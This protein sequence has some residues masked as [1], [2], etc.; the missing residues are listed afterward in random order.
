MPS[1]RRVLLVQLPIPSLGPQPIR[2]NVPLAAGY[3]KLWAR[4]Q[5]LDE[6]LD[7][8]ILPAREVNRCG[9][10]ALVD[11]IDATD[12]ALVGFTCYVW[13]IDRTLWAA[14]ELKRRRP[15]TLIV[16]G[17]PE[18]TAD[19][20]W[21][22]EHGA[23]DIAVV[24]EGEQTF[25]EVL[26]TCFEHPR[27]LDPVRG[28]VF[29]DG[30]R[31]VRTPPRHPLASLDAISSP[32]LAGIL[33]AADQEQL[34]LETVRGCV[35]RCKFCYYPKAYDGLYFVSRERVLLN[36]AHARDRGAREVYILDPTLNQRRDFADFLDVLREG[37]P[38]GRL[39]YH[40]ELRGEGIRPEHARRMREANFKEV[41]IGLQSVDPVAQKT[42]DRP[43]SLKA[44]ERGVRALQE[45]GIRVKADL[46][47]GL[48]GDRAESVR[49]GMHFLA[50]NRLYDDI[51]L[52]Q[53]SVLP[54]TEF[55]QTA[56]ELGIEFQPRPPYYALRTPDLSLDEIR[57]LQLE[58]EDVFGVEFDP[59]GPPV[60]DVEG[61]TEAPDGP[62]R[63]L[64]L[65]LDGAPNPALPRSTSLAFTLWLR[66]RNPYSQL[67]RAAGAV[68]ALLRPNPFTTL[69][70]VI[71]TGGEF[72][73][74]V[75]TGLR[76]A[77]AR[78]ENSY[79][80][81]FFEFTPS[82][83][84]GSLRFVCVF[85]AAKRASIDPD[86]VAGALRHS[87]VVWV[88]PPAGRDQVRPAGQAGEWVWERDSLASI[89]AASAAL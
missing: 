4:G 18:V 74:D 7:V 78:S 17:G 55:R 61:L 35:F 89:K 28:L 42:M 43:T 64:V 9:D 77:S 58:A 27:R 16:L 73:L 26:H 86:W 3:L 69:Q 12:P 10:Q 82:S 52:F 60:L 2:G 46:I 11:A 37:N 39:E 56:R 76:A 44:F 57:A 68:R 40:A 70:L 45:E 13:N 65:D 8:E 88:Q 71:E 6:R 51:Q 72:P 38:D 63:A 25:A 5:G 41:E 67:N 84:S 14:R 62:M 20:A 75:F 85:P 81:R 54:G 36:L 19:N 80:D 47:V 49:N 21:V 48:P 59:P 32:Y 79:L 31:L 66:T 30:E 83:T 87:D 23:H 53:L 50:Q 34:L 1:R 24:G 29:R 33:D 22:L 15:E